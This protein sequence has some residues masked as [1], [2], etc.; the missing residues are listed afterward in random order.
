MSCGAPIHPCRRR[1][2]AV[3]W[4]PACP[5]LGP[6]P[7]P[8][9]DLPGPG[10]LKRPE[11]SEGPRSCWAVEPRQAPILRAPLREQ[12]PGAGSPTPGP[13]PQRCTHPAS[14]VRGPRAPQPRSAPHLGRGACLGRVGVKVTRCPLPG[15]RGRGA[16]PGLERR[17]APPPARPRVRPNFPL[18]APR[19]QR[20]APRL[21]AQSGRAAPPAPAAPA[22]DR[23]TPA[24]A[25]SPQARRPARPVAREDAVAPEWLLLLFA[26]GS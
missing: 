6:C 20:R 25:P 14:R 9:R 7:A 13:V 12:G 1:A 21:A 18:P 8:A 24:G 15:G 5:H 22:A 19:P 17:G 3:A 26:C 23:G 16:R 10:A 11:R 2:A 4:G